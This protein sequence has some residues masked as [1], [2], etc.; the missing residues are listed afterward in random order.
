LVGVGRSKPQHLSTA[1]ETIAFHS[2][3]KLPL[4][5]LA[6]PFM[7]SGNSG[8]GSSAPGVLKKLVAGSAK[9]VIC[10]P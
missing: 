3:R 6:R 4:A 2:T 7:V 5:L 9:D 8:I 1:N 10:S